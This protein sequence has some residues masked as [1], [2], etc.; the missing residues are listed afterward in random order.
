MCPNVHLTQKL[1][2]YHH[3]K[4]TV[5]SASEVWYSR[6]PMGIHYLGNMMKKI[7]EDVFTIYVNINVLLGLVDLLLL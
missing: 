4:C 2:F 7:S 6:E 1:A 3:P 5:T